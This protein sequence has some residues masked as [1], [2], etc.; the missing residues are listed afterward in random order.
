MERT[1]FVILI[2][3]LKLH[4]LD[5]YYIPYL[6]L[7]TAAV[8]RATLVSARTLRAFPTYPDPKQKRRRAD[9]EEPIFSLYLPT[10]FV[11]R[12][13]PSQAIGKGIYLISQAV[14][15]KVCFATRTELTYF[16]TY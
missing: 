3:G 1:F 16:R 8:P 4:L 11:V 2:H 12:Q 10:L 7:I 14:A 6:R 15:S 5:H 13:G 9:D